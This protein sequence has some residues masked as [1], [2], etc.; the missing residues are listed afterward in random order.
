MMRVGSRPARPLIFG[1][2][3]L[4]PEAGARA[5]GAHQGGDF[6]YR[7]APD[8]PVRD[9]D[10]GGPAG[11]RASPRMRRA[12]L[13]AADPGVRDLAGAGDADCRSGR[14]AAS[15]NDASRGNPC[16][17][18]GA[19]SPIAA[20]GASD[21]TG[22]G[23][24]RSQR[25]TGHLRPASEVAQIARSVVSVSKRGSGEQAELGY[26]TALAG[27]PFARVRIEGRVSFAGRVALGAQAARRSCSLARSLSVPLDP[28]GEPW[29]PI[30]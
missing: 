6:R 3:L 23:T 7:L 20:L 21:M 26:R 9:G 5:P 17:F 24:G 22:T 25:M 8:G 28:R 15:G 12:E 30:R 14:F 13:W 10:G 19:R 18:A 27:G 1:E 16:A 29:H 2:R 4:V 11:A